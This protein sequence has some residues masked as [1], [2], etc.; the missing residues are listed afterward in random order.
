MKHIIFPEANPH[1]SNSLVIIG[2]MFAVSKLW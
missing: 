1:I 2:Y